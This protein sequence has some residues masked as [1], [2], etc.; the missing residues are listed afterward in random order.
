M[1]D[2]TVKLETDVREIEKVLWILSKITNIQRTKSK[3]NSANEVVK[4]DTIHYLTFSQNARYS[5]I[6]FNLI[7]TIFSVEP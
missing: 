2:V 6:Q 7:R 3:F 5:F 4:Y 1:S